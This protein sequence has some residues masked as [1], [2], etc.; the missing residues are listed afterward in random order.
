MGNL[1]FF[2]DYITKK[3]VADM[4]RIT[5]LK[6]SVLEILPMEPKILEVKK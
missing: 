1:Y 4:E 6:H 5:S 3:T 2:I